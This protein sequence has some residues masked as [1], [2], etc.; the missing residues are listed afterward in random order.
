LYIQ[1]CTSSTSSRKNWQL[2]AEISILR[3]LHQTP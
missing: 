3:F 2:D 1:L